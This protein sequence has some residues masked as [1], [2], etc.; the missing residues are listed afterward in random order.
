MRRIALLGLLVLLSACSS[1]SAT[2]LPE[3]PNSISVQSLWNLHKELY[4]GTLKI[5]TMSGHGSG[6]AIK[7]KNGY[8]YVLTSE[9]VVD[10]D[11]RP[12]VVQYIGDDVAATPGEVIAS[13]RVRDLA[14]I[15]V[16]ARYPVFELMTAAEY[17][18]VKEPWLD[19]NGK[20]HPG[21][22][23]LGAGFGSIIEPAM[24]VFGF[25]LETYHDSDEM[26]L[27][28]YASCGGWFGCSGGPVMHA[29]TGKIIGVLAL[30]YNTNSHLLVSVSPSEI[31]TFLKVAKVRP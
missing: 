29:A 27:G 14:V 11:K 5:S 9:H 30:I 6:F 3:L 31:W 26:W 13:S 1:F 28:T 21:D 10:H 24:P 4:E 18:K 17:K 19:R 23:L 16:K 2:R 8:S 12:L 15:K 25:V 7:Y 20:F 22:L